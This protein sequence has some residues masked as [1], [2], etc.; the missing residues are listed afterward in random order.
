MTQADLAQAANVVSNT[1]RNLE[2]YGAEEVHARKDTVEAIH[3]ALDRAGVEC[4]A[5]NGR[6]VGVR[7]RKSGP[8][9]AGYQAGE[10]QFDRGRLPVGRQ[11]EIR[12]HFWLR[13]NGRPP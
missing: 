3:S 10:S 11:H 1:I 8:P 4:I 9:A 6:G 7:L 5:E 13:L 2:G 12:G